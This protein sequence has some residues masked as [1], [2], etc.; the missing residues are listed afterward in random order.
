MQRNAFLR[1]CY[2]NKKCPNN[3]KRNI[4]PEELSSANDLIIVTKVEA[5]SFPTLVV[6]KVEEIPTLVV[7]KVEEIPTLVVAKVLLVLNSNLLFSGSEI[8]PGDKISEG[9]SLA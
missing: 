1:V 8:G 4:H 9:P 6:A 7:A 3:V 5:I 2:Y